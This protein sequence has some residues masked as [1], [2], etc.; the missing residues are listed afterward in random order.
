MTSISWAGPN[1]EATV[2][3]MA[4]VENVAA[5]TL[6]T[7]HRAISTIHGECDKINSN[8]AQ[9]DIEVNYEVQL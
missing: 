2:W 4:L 3:R 8:T 1:I 6:R 5:V 9:G 7:T